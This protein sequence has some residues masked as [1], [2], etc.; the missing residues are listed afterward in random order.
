VNLFLPP[1]AKAC[2]RIVSPL[3]HHRRDAILFPC[4]TKGATLPLDRCPHPSTPRGQSPH[5]ALIYSGDPRGEQGEAPRGVK[6]EILAREMLPE[7]TGHR[8]GS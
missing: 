3:I 6:V 4:V 1:R 8:E 7:R 2:H 5:A